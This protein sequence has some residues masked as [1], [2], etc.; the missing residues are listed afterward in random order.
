MHNWQRSPKVEGD[1]IEVQL[2]ILEVVAHDAA[3]LVDYHSITNGDQLKITHVQR[4]NIATLADA[5]SLRRQTIS[6]SKSL[7]RCTSAFPL[8]HARVSVWR[9]KMNAHQSAV[10]PCEEGCSTEVVSKHI[11]GDIH[12]AANL[13][14]HALSTPRTHTAS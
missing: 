6:S 13:R 8:R 12:K 1:L 11:G 9:V 4:I 14:T 10:P 5:G 2:A 3:A 7:R